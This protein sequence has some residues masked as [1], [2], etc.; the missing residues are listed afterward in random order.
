MSATRSDECLTA[1]QTP[2]A[3]VVEL[4]RRP[5]LVGPETVSKRIERLTPQWRRPLRPHRPRRTDGQW[6]PPTWGILPPK[7]LR[8]ASAAPAQLTTG[9]P[10]R[11]VVQ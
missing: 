7:R 9:A 10:P 1:V 6:D 8:C 11:Y 3:V 5:A 4:L 2:I